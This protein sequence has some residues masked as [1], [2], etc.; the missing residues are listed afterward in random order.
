M[1]NLGMAASQEGTNWGELIGAIGIGALGYALISGKHA[2]SEP[3]TDL[4]KKRL[5]HLEY[6]HVIKP[7]SLI[8]AIPE[9]QALYGEAVDAYLFGLP[10]ASVPM[11][12]RCLELALGHAYDQAG[13]LPPERNT[14]F[15]LIEWSEQL[16]GYRKEFAHGFRLL[17]NL[18]H[19]P[20]LVDEPTALEVLRH[21]SSI[22]NRV[23]PLPDYGIRRYVCAGCLREQDAH[24][25][26]SECWLGNITRTACSSC[27]RLITLQI[28]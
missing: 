6:F 23:L 20:T 22:I 17:R 25:T 10:N 3:Q 13:R 24:I 15:E 9:T 11:S 19:E 5:S 1:Y 16:L 27:G 7:I 26:V 12:I 4:R 14:L 18:I 8:R 2:E 21:V 28:T